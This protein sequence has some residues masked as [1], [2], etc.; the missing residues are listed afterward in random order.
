MTDVSNMKQ[1]R[2]AAK[3]V[4]EAITTLTARRSELE[5]DRDGLV[6]R[7]QTLMT[8]P[9]TREDAKQ[10]ILGTVDRQSEEFI[11]LADW[12]ANFRAFALP[13]GDGR[14]QRRQVA[15]KGDGKAAGPLSLMDIDQA[16]SG[17]QLGLNHVVGSD[18][19]SFFYGGRRLDD[20][21]PSRLCFFFGDLI[22]NKIDQH[23]DELFPSVISSHPDAAISVAARRAEVDANNAR[24]VALGVEVKAIDG[25]LRELGARGVPA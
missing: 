23:F 17:G 7:N 9:V 21:A 25:Q 10:F 12:G 13:Q 24:L 11:D 20:M 2:D 18:F 6:S 19:R 3:V 5:S 22:K 1:A 16:N 8:L 4:R 15:T 14:E